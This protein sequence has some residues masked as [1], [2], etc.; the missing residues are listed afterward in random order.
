[1]QIF[2]N[3]YPPPPALKLKSPSQLPKSNQNATMNYRE[4]VTADGAA[5]NVI[6][7]PMHSHFSFLNHF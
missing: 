7:R 2:Q 4:G 3:N 1:M 6:I 5:M